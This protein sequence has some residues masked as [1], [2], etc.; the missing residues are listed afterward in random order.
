MNTGVFLSLDTVDR[1][2]TAIGKNRQE[3]WCSRGGYGIADGVVRNARA[4]AARRNRTLWVIGT[5]TWLTMDGLLVIDKPVG[6]TSHDVVARVRRLLRERRIGHTGTLD[7]MASGVLP[8]LVGRATRLA[9]FY[10]A[11]EKR[12][13]AIVRL[14]VV[15]DTY[16]A[17]GRPSGPAYCGR[18][19][20]RETIERTLDRFRGEFIQQPPAYSAKKIDGQRSYR[21]ARGRR[22]S[23]EADPDGAAAVAEMPALPAPV[24]V[25]TSL[26]RLVAVDG[27]DVTLD[28]VCS[29]GFYV[30]SLAHDL[31]AA[32]GTGGHLMALRRTASGEI[33][34]AQAIPLAALEGSDGSDRAAAALMPLDTLLPSLPAADLT[35]EGDERVRQGRDVGPGHISGNRPLPPDATAIRLLSTGGQLIAIAER[36]GSPGFLHPAIVLV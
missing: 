21:L 24:P 10:S 26:L 31:G 15:T 4:E 8:L 17:E 29:A 3:C 35:L 28:I 36:G 23:A 13:E 14:G 25:K 18:W 20:D 7:P 16:D 5:I 1:R 12:Y 6:P 34:L 19:P 27:T 11:R 32:L 22:R 33:G 9:R 2:R 30:R